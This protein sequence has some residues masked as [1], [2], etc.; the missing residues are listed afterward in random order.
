VQGVSSASILEFLAAAEKAGHELHGFMVARHGN[1]IAEGWW[2]PYRSGAVHSLYS[3][4]KSFTSTAVGFVVA[5]GKLNVEEHVLKFFPDQR[6]PAVSD[7]LAALRVRD[8][9]DMSVGHATDS[10]PI[11][12]KEHD[13]V[14][15]FLSLP[16][17][18]PPGS[19]FLYDSGASYMLSA[20]VQKLSGQRVHDYLKPRLFD[21][22]EIQGTTWDSCP[23]GVN[24]GGW[25][26][27]VTTDALLKFGQLYLRLGKWN[28]KQL[29]PREWVQEATTAKIQQPAAFLPS[30]GADL[31]KLKQTSDWHQGYAYQFWRCRHNAF[32]GDGAFGQ[33][34]IVLP[35]QEAV[36][37]IH[38]NS[39]NLQDLL[40]IVWEHLLPAMHDR[41]L[42]RD[43]PAE[44]QLKQR[45]LSLA[46]PVPTGAPSSVSMS[47]ITGKEFRLDP[48]SLGAE[49]ISFDFSKG[50][51]VFSLKHEKGVSNVRGGLGKW[52][53][54]VTNM[55]GT[56]PEVTSI[57]GVKPADQRLPAKV[58]GAAAWKDDDTFE[59][60]WHFYETPHHN[61]VIS[62]FDG[63]RI[64]VEILNSITQPLSPFY[65]S[66]PS[67]RDTKPTLT[68]R[69]VA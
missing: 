48:N 51:C 6:P 60:A 30:P 18:H 22:L 16:I 10:T 12:T 32:R 44:T 2:T 49:T 63:D 31:E 66:L 5:E 9:L 17:E 8:L 35:E 43:A 34:C 23:L 1:I 52:V 27:S 24:T 13:W 50:S 39:R 4:S 56:P 53:D 21:P 41:V 19:T 25:G 45:L 33:F 69:M 37:A 59:M 36:I 29:L 58:A 20:V 42:S 68:G 61:L 47:K 3:L 26:L 14:K 28:G 11:I 62:R 57:I 7:N 15:T 64:S 46:L 40:N 38:S 54:G 67:Q 65:P 55:P